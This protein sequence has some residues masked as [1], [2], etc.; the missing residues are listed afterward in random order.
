MPVK[1]KPVSLAGSK[2]Y[3]KL[4]PGAEDGTPERL[5]EAARTGEVG[6]ENGVRRLA[7]PFDLLRRR[8]TLH[9]RDP[10]V[11]DRLW[12]IGDRFRRHW[13]GSRLDS[14]TAFDFTRELVDGTSGQATTPTEAATRHRAFIR[15]AAV[16]VGPRLMPILMGVVVEA[17]QAA[18]LAHLI[19]ESDHARTAETLVIERLRESLHRLGDHWEMADDPVP[20]GR[21]RAASPKLSP[22]PSP[23]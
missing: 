23:D 15:K 9:R 5:A 22:A 13:H 19:G 20:R 12:E 17:R 18:T 11:N 21:Y 16:A 1:G 6:A 3:P 10:A 4:A 2:R 8:Q 7:D 14:L